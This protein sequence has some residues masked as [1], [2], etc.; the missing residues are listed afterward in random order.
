MYNALIQTVKANYNN[1]YINWEYSLEYIIFQTFSWTPDLIV[2]HLKRASLLRSL[3][4]C[5]IVQDCP[6]ASR[7]FI[8]SRDFIAVFNPVIWQ[9]PFYNQGQWRICLTNIHKGIKCNR[10]IGIYLS[11]SSVQQLVLNIS[12][13]SDATFDWNWPRSRVSCHP[14]LP[15]NFWLS[16]P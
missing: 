9:Y 6:N 8:T 11:I 12:Y 1:P 10:R 13:S 14:P 5:R 3:L 7:F 4:T 2:L 15:K 16:F